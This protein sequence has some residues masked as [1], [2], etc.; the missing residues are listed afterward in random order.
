[1]CAVSLLCG[2]AD[3]EMQP[4]VLK[5][6]PPPF[7]LCGQSATCTA[8]QRCKTQTHIWFKAAL[9]LFLCNRTKS[10]FPPGINMQVVSGF[11]AIG[12]GRWSWQTRQQTWSTSGNAGDCDVQGNDPCLAM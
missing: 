4:V 6:T 7:S 5:L 10:P 11:T 12:L 1:M 9:G 8:L 2:N 3:V